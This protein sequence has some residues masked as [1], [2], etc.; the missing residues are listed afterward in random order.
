MF[1]FYVDP[2]LDLLFE[3]LTGQI[4]ALPRLGTQICFHVPHDL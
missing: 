1:S 2:D 3:K 4:G